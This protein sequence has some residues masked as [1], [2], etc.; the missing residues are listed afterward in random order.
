MAD[1]VTLEAELYDRR[2][3]DRPAVFI[4]AKGAKVPRELADKFGGVY[5][6]PASV[7]ARKEADVEDKAVKPATKSVRTKKD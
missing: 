4:A 1:E 2:D 7:K 5:T 6:K 3:P